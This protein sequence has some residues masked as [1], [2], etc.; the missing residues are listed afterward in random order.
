MTT[1]SP[2]PCMLVLIDTEGHSVNA[3][4]EM[5]EVLRSGAKRPIH[6]SVLRM[7]SDKL[8]TLPPGVDDL[9]DVPL[10]PLP[11][12]LHSLVSRAQRSPI[13]RNL[14]RMSPWDRGVRVRQSIR[15]FP[16][17]L[18][19]IHGAQVLLAGGRDALLTVWT[20]SRSRP[21]M[22]AVYGMRSAIRAVDEATDR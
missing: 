13:G 17:A 20:V 19:R 2:E 12:A 15:D 8:P 22:A 14:V 3:L 7:G 6:L 21:D 16:E 11:A 4:S 10:Q 1:T 5:A 9:V 18:Q